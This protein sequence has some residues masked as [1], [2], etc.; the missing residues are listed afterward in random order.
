M[1]MGWQWLDRTSGVDIGAVKCSPYDAAARCLFTA[2]MRTTCSAS[3]GGPG[4]AS[5][6]CHVRMVL[7]EALPSDEV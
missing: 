6:L 4:S 2:L 5:T 1:I 7:I 3:A